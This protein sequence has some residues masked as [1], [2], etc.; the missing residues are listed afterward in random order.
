MRDA[1]PAVLLDI[2]DTIL[3]FRSAEAA[4]LR[5]SFD[6]MEICADDALIAR[7]S[8]INRSQWELLEEGVLTRDQVLVRRFELLFEEY[9]IPR[10]GAE[11]TERYE[12]ELCR[13][14]WFMPGAEELLRTLSPDYRLFL[15]SNGSAKV[16][17]ARLASAGIAGF[18]ERIFISEAL[19]AEKPTREFF[20]R[21][22]AVIPAFD[23]ARAILVGDSLSSDIRGAK[24]AGLF[25]C[26]YNYRRR[27]GRPDIVPD[28]EIRELSELPPLLARLFPTIRET[29]GEKL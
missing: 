24:N 9:G 6:A 23:P 12:N 8:E 17:A 4:A 20:D 7:Y 29:E 3:D 19:G 10:S 22:F 25:S 14:H 28:W 18:F 16:Q 2:D 11:A 13:G 26:W 27:P 21:C 1:R 5:R 15:V